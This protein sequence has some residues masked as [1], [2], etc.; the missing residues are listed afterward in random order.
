MPIRDPIPDRIQAPG[1]SVVF[2]RGGTFHVP[3]KADPTRIFNIH[4]PSNRTFH[5]A[6]VDFDV[7]HGGWFAKDPSGNH[8][9]FWLH[10]GSYGGPQDWP[11][12][13][14][15]ITGFANAF[16]PGKGGNAV[17]VVSN[18]GLSKKQDKVRGKAGVTLQAG[19][20]YH[21]HFDYDT[22]KGKATLKLTRAGAPVATTVM[23]TTVK[24]LRADSSQ[25]WMI[26]FGH[27]N[28]YGK[29]VGAERPTYGWK[30]Q[31]LEVRFIP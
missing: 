14:G 30:Y 6:V 19:K 27:E 31:N 3:T 10:R 7:Y 9:L 12:W 17:K 25:T 13:T 5:R 21:V 28:E 26:Y 20:T 15:N 2:T 23:P 11:Q 16:G 1:S 8:S 24:T 4:V 22:G 18:M 29:N